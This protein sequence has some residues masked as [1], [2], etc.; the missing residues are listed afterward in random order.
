METSYVLEEKELVL[1]NLY[2]HYSDFSDGGRNKLVGQIF[3]IKNPDTNKFVIEY[4]SEEILKDS[5]FDKISGCDHFNGKR[6][7]VYNNKVP[8]FLQE[9]L[10]SM[11]RPDLPKLLEEIGLEHFDIYEYLKRTNGV[12]SDNRLFV[13]TD[14]YIP[15]FKN[16]WLHNISLRIN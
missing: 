9:R 12:C 3:E 8:I 15:N 13:H 10:P 1:W 4:I 6:L 7:W 2:I 5:N 11:R 14:K 16:E